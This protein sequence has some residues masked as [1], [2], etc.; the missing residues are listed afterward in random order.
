MPQ[1]NESF[2]QQVFE[3]ATHRCEYCK[4]P[5]RMIGMPLII[6]HIL[7]KS[8]GGVDSF[9]NVCAA[10]YR[11][12]EFKGAKTTGRDPAN[13]ETVVLF[14]PR[15]DPWQKHFRWENGGTYIV[16]QTAMGRATVLELRL[17]N[18]Y[19]VDSRSLWITYGE[20]PPTEEKRTESE[21]SGL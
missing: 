16:G 18:D 14:N 2:R 9:E 13:G 15:I 10:C 1:L 4:T 11:C 12:N 8:R 20:H 3:R 5:Q 17:N 6:D 19:V 21:N 7:P